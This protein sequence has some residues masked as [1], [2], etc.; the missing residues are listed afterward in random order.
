M[1]VDLSGS[2]FFEDRSALRTDFPVSLPD[3]YP[4]H[5]TEDPAHRPEWLHL[6]KVLEAYQQG[7]PRTQIMLG[8]P[9]SKLEKVFPMYRWADR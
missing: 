8:T 7:F 9:N 5:T 4:V 2:Y 1:G 3:H 6:S